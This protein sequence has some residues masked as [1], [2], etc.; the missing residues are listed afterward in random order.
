MVLTLDISPDK[1]QRLQEQ[2]LQAGLPLNEFLRRAVEQIADPL[3]RQ[4]SDDSEIPEQKAERFLRWAD[5]H[6]RTKPVIPTETMNR[7]HFYEE[8]G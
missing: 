8:R 4:T 5:G 6:N 7:E 1:A 2:A 3:P